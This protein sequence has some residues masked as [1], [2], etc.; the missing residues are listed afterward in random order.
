MPKLFYKQCMLHV[1]QKK[2]LLYDTINVFQYLYLS[3]RYGMMLALE[4]QRWVYLLL[5]SQQH[6]LYATR[7]RSSEGRI[8]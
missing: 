1:L 4:W 2:T 5:S 8:V 3:V 6:N 7:L